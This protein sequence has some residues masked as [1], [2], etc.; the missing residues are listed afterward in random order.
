MREEVKHLNESLA[1]EK[2]K[3]D[4]DTMLPSTSDLTI[5]ERYLTNTGSNLLDKYFAIQR[6]DD[7]RYMMG[8]KEIVVDKQSNMHVDG[9]EYKGTPG[10]WALVMLAKPKY[11]EYTSDDFSRYGDLV[12]QTNVINHP[13]NI[14]ARSR[15]ASTWKW[16]HILTPIMQPIKK[17]NIDGDGIQF[18][19]SDIKGLTSKL[20]LLLAEFAA[21]NRSSTRN[22]I[23]FI[24]DELLRRK[25]ISRKEYTDI[26]SYLSKCL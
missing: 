8:D 19:P 21:G 3:L 1:V 15:P 25:K 18:L 2:A 14:T 10:L 17:E 26:N 5:V 13:Q 20:H 6:M 16:K 24:L 12:K 22:E 4:D 9:V 11:A 7:G 23:V